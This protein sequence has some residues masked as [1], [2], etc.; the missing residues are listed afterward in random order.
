[1]RVMYDFWRFLRK[2]LRV[3]STDIQR[4]DTQSIWGVRKSY[5]MSH[6]RQMQY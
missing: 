2:K 4:A 1:M 6:T 3:N 5:D